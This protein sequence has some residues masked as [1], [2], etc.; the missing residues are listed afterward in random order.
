MRWSLSSVLLLALASGACG[1]KAPAA[2]QVIEG[3]HQKS[4]WKAACYFPRDYRDTDRVAQ[5]DVRENMMAQW[6]GERDDG[7][8]FSTSV[9]ER[10]ETALLSKPDAVKG[11]ARQNLEYCA[12]VMSGEAQVSEWQGWIG[13]LATTLTEG[14]CKWPPLRYQQHDYLEVDQGWQFEGRVCKGDRIRIEVSALDYYRVSDSGPWINAEG[15]TS[16][17]ALGENYACTIEG[18]YVGTVIYR[19]TGEDG[20]ITIG[21]VG[22]QL[23]FTAKQHGILHLQVNDDGTWFD[24]VWRKK[25]SLIDHAAIAYI[26]LD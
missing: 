13:G 19:F 5:N 4:G 12:K 16:Q 6:R 20:S 10:L 25:G 17:Q 24:N 3:W 15:D 18:C 21:P 14:D 7:V 11:V 2:A 9:L 23:E 1:K 22:T 26:G 8:S